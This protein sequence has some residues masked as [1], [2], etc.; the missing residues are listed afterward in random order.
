METSSRRSKSGVVLA[1]ATSLIAL[2]GCGGDDDVTTP[3]VTAGETAAP[4]SG[5]ADTS[6]TVES[7]SAESG[8]GGCPTGAAVSAAYGLEMEFNT[9]FSITEDWLVDEMGGATCQYNQVLAPDATDP[10]GLD[11]VAY[12]ATIELMHSDPITQAV[13]AEPVDGVGDAAVWNGAQLSVRAGDRGVRVTNEM[14][15]P[16]PDARA[17]AI[18]LATLALATEWPGADATEAAVAVAE[19]V[20]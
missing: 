8:P 5:R 17:V 9:D 13:G 15:P 10:S 3:P 7:G 12:I 11:A 4:T 19:V 6:A 14:P 16:G 1:A 20:L 2:A 18:A